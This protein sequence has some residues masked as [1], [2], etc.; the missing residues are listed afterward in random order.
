MFLE[1][2]PEPPTPEPVLAGTCNDQTFEG[3]EADRPGVTPGLARQSMLECGRRLLL[4]LAAVTAT[5]APVIAVAPAGAAGRPNVIVI[6]VDD[7]RA[8][9]LAYMPFTRRLFA[10]GGMTFTDSI[11]P[12]PLCCPARA[13]L[14]TGQYA[15]NNG[16]HHNDGPFGGWDALTSRNQMVPEWFQ[17]AGYK[18]GFTGK[19]I[20]HYEGGHIQGLTDNDAFSAGT[21]R[22]TGYEVWNNGNPRTPDGH[23]TDYIANHTGHLAQKY[24]KGSA[25]FFLW[26][27]FVAP[28]TMETRDGRIVNP[29]P[30]ARY[31]SLRSPDHA[32]PQSFDSA[33]YREQDLSDKPSTFVRRR[34][35]D[36]GQVDQHR[37]RVLSLYAVDDGVRRIVAD[38]EAA[39]VYADTAWC[40]PATTGS[41]SAS[42]TPRRRTG[43]IRSRC[44]CRCFSRARVFLPGRPAPASPRSSTSPARWRSSP[45]S[46]P[47]GCRTART[48]SRSRRTGP[49]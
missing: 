49:C 9:D 47:A 1:P 25:P 35:S 46:A 24:A 11:S 41:S 21:Y 34:I 38:L 7:M 31:D 44:A 15:Q 32:R 6:L 33:A 20:N 16:V 4:V 12:H 10:T 5:L 48:C 45:E 8:D 29:I 14:L 3:T 39:G 26:A 18:T 17:R 42:T 22:P 43:P 27:G 23:Q 37:R 13:E 28:H 19:F 36:Q 30:P 40:S 2:R